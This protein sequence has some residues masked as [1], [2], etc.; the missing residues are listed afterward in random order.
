MDTR[1]LYI[2]L[3][4]VLQVL[5]FRFCGSFGDSLL[6]LIL[7]ECWIYLLALKKL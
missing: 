4:V 5:S 7:R 3:V 6:H 1:C 2:F